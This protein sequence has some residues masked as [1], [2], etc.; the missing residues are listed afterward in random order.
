M[1]TS[2]CY[3]TSPWVEASDCNAAHAT[4]AAQKLSHTQRFLSGMTFWKERDY[5]HGS[6]LCNDVPDEK[7]YMCNLVWPARQV[8]SF[9]NGGTDQLML[10]AKDHLKIFCVYF[11]AQK[12]LQLL[13]L[14]MKTL[15][16]WLLPMCSTSSVSVPQKSALH[17]GR[18]RRRMVGWFAGAA[19]GCPP[20]T[21]SCYRTLIATSIF[22]QINLE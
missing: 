19:A 9:G 14:K 6:G 2:S 13:L 1:A 17:V 22:W 12:R 7:E 11:E 21:N 3:L 15:S 18:K 16:Q 20:V 10:I 8:P 5:W 4:L